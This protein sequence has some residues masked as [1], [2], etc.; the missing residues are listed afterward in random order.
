MSKGWELLREE[1]TVEK[2][3]S[4]GAMKRRV[5]RRKKGL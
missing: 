1:G 5:G 2:M 4:L 3:R